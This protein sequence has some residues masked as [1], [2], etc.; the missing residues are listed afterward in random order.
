MQVPA[1]LP[2]HEWR[3]PKPAASVGS[4]QVA[5]EVQAPAPVQVKKKVR[6]VRASREPS[7]EVRGDV[8]E[9]GSRVVVVAAPAESAGAGAGK[10]TG[11]GVVLSVVMRAVAARAEVEASQAV[12]DASAG[13]AVVEAPRV[14]ASAGAEASR[15]EVDGVEAEGPAED[16]AGCQLDLSPDGDP[17]RWRRG[18]A[19]MFAGA[20]FLGV[21]VVGLG[22]MVSGWYV[23]RYSANE[24]SRGTGYSDEALAPLRAQQGRGE[25]MLAAGAVTAVFGA[26]LGATLM[27][28]GA[29]DV[30]AGRAA[31]W[32][33]V[34]VAP[35]LGG[36]VLSGQF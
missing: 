33:G 36:L 6:R 4:K 18:R 11:S 8:A 30:R 21:G 17:A 35:S 31:R 27:V 19:Q 1:E 9:E 12:A 13:G 10:V 16:V 3:A 2:A 15:V 29:R 22:V 34:R 23:Q 24:L 7:V 32:S 28:T 20:A 5:A 26:A 14:V 25:T